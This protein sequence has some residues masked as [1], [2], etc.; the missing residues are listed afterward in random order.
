MPRYLAIDFGSKRIGLAIG[1]SGAG[2]ASPLKT[3]EATGRPAADIAAVLAVCREY[4]VDALV[5]GLPLNMDGTEGSQAKATRAFGD[6][7]ATAG[8]KR[9]H[10]HDE[11]LSSYAAE[12]LLQGEA[13][14]RKK[15][16]PRLDRLAAQVI[17][18]DFLASQGADSVQQN[19]HLGDTD[20][21]D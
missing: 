9:V 10:Y 14:T 12:G 7:L 15:K 19:T 11:R 18:Q 20:E 8:G 4:E 5:I 21:S 17:L 16:R 6:A 3:L 2:I 13:L 1:D